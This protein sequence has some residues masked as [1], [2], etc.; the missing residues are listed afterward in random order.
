MKTVKVEL[1]FEVGTIKE[2]GYGGYK[3]PWIDA[4][5]G[6]KQFDLTAGAGV[7]SSLLEASVREEGKP[8]IYAIADIQ[9]LAKSIWNVLRDEQENASDPEGT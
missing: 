6:D 5:S 1:E 7:G 8:S 9:P 4:T 2:I 3:V